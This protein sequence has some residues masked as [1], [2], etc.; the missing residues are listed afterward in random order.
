M[1]ALRGFCAALSLGSALC[2]GAQ[3][4]SRAF[5]LE[6]MPAAARVDTREYLPSG[7]LFNRE[8]GRMDGWALGLRYQ[9]PSALVGSDRWSI[10]A[11]RAAADGRVLYV[12]FAQGGFP[13]VTFTDLRVQRRELAVWRHWEASQRLR[14]GLAASA[15]HF[16]IDRKILPGLNLPLQEVLNERTRGLH[17]ELSWHVR[18]SMPMVPAVTTIRAAGRLHGSS[19]LWVNSYG[20][21]DLITLAPAKSRSHAR[22]LEFVWPLTS[23]SGAGLQSSLVFQRQLERFSPGES[24]TEIWTRGGAPTSTVRYPGARIDLHHKAVG[25][26][27]NW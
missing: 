20:V 12:G 22:A 4:D 24:R 8:D 17:G 21:Q 14:V 18:S 27:L 25:I 5:Q 6:V 23:A 15:G 1:K 10:Q 3:A 7:A 2:A 19:S 16:Q 9:L 26:Q 11:Q 13:L